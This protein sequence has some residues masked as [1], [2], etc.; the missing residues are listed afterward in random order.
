MSKRPLK[1]PELAD[2][3]SAVARREYFNQ[4][5]SLVI[6]SGDQPV[7]QLAHNIEVA[8]GTGLSHQTVYRALTGPK[9]PSRRVVALLDEELAAG[10]LLLELWSE[11][12]MEERREGPAKKKRV[13]LTSR[14]VQMLTAWLTAGSKSE[15][16]ATL[17]VSP[18]TVATH[19]ARIRVKYE[20]AGRPASSKTALLRRLVE[21]GYVQLDDLELVPRPDDRRI[22]RLQL[23]SSTKVASD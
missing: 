22:E 4:A 17:F 23:A 20:K 9:L 12:V 16:A 15:A 14:E 21:D 5:Q 11:A 8:H 10:G 7:A 19:V 6:R 3:G 13:N 2:D 1:S 18:T